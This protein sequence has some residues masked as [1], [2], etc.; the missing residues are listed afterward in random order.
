MEQ[1]HCVTRDNVP[2]LGIIQLDDIDANTMVRKLHCLNKCG[3]FTFMTGCELVY[4]DEFNGCFIHTSNIT[5]GDGD[6]NANC[7]MIKAKR[8]RRRQYNNNFEYFL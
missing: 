6:V 7:W 5:A 4:G 1:G 2:P 8:R 3:Q